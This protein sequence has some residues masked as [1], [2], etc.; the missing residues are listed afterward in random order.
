[1]ASEPLAE[2]PVELPEGRSVLEG[3]QLAE[4]AALAVEQHELEAL[5]F[6]GL[7]ALSIERFLADAVAALAVAAAIVA[8]DLLLT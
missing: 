1:M 6:P 8:A 7:V 2:S 3:V 5:G 4:S